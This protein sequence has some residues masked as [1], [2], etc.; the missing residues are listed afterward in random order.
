MPEMM[1]LAIDGTAPRSTTN[2]IVDS[3][4]WNSRIARGNQMIEGIVWSPV[5]ADPI[6]ARSGLNRATAIP[7]SDPTSTDSANPVRARCMV[8]PMAVQ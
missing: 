1:P 6:A 2:M 3:E 4:I 5:I 7:R 8:M